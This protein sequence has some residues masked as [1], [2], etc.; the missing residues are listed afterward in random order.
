MATLQFDEQWLRNYC[1]RTGKKMPDLQLSAAGADPEKPMRSKYGNAPTEHDGMRFASKHEAQVYEI[2]R[3]QCLNGEHL[4][5]GCQV[6]FYLPGGVK[7]IADF[8][9][10]EP[11]GSFTVYDA[12]SEATRKDKVYRLKKRQMKECLGIQIVET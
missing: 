6:A 12:K 7:Y 4:G 11:D 1:K 10:L 8:V 2:L 9:T 5:L 3:L